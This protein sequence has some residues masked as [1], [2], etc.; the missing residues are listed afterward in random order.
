MVWSLSCGTLLFLKWV[1]SGSSVGENNWH[2]WLLWTLNHLA[3]SR[4][5]KNAVQRYNQQA[6]PVRRLSQDT[7]RFPREN[8]WWRDRWVHKILD[9]AGHT[10]S[11]QTDVK[12][13]NFR[14]EAPGG[15]VS[16]SIHPDQTFKNLRYNKNVSQCFFKIKLFSYSTKFGRF[17]TKPF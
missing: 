3:L 17:I 9:D 5:N 14:G 7:G 11:S 16:R 13:C 8:I 2:V 10:P 15:T 4:H 6:S 12:C 1:T